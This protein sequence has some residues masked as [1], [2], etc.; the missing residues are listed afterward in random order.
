MIDVD[1]A[2]K[3]TWILP[4]SEVTVQHICL[5][6]AI[7]WFGLH[8]TLESSV[9]CLLRK[10][11]GRSCHAHQP[12]MASICTLNIVWEI[13]ETL[14]L[15]SKFYILFLFFPPTHAFNPIACVHWLGLYAGV[16]VLWLWDIINQR[17][18][19]SFTTWI[20]PI[21]NTLYLC[22]MHFLL[23]NVAWLSLY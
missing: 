23:L 9:S 4:P 15:L 22:F 16:Q 18:I 20:F 11:D 2:A 17:L 12:R 5:E 8:N 10:N 1:P 13:C 21:C 3:L 6:L 19:A 7:W 14:L